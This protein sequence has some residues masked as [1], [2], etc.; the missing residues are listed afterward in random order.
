[1][2]F[3]A[4]IEGSDPFTDK[5]TG[6]KLVHYG[7]E[8]GGINLPV[9][10]SF[11][12]SMLQ[13][14]FMST[15]GQNPY[16]PNGPQGD[17]LSLGGLPTDN[18][19]DPI[20]SGPWVNPDGPEDEYTFDDWLAD[21]A[22]LPEE[23]RGLPDGPYGGTKGGSTFDPTGGVR[24]QDPF[25]TSG[26]GGFDAIGWD[27]STNEDFYAQQFADARGQGARN[28]FGEYLGRERTRQ[29]NVAERE[30]IAGIDRND[31]F[32][33]TGGK[34]PFAWAEGGSEGMEAQVAGAASER[35]LNDRLVEGMTASQMLATYGK[36]M[37]EKER[38]YL[39]KQATQEGSNWSEQTNWSTKLRN[40]MSPDE[41]LS[42]IGGQGQT[43]QPNEWQRAAY[44]KLFN[45][46]GAKQDPSG[47]S[48]AE[49]YALPVRQQA[50]ADAAAAAATGA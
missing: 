13:G 39:T 33:M 16:F 11:G 50:Q 20:D 32:A 35:G 10:T 3:F 26:A 29:N 2:G 49:G 30:R 44:G 1:M 45:L 28:Q 41:L 48:A 5:R 38:N 12:D 31:P 15:G 19:Y 24:P 23:E 9:G 6:E 8:N 42:R 27:A 17:E 40:G 47:P 4:D 36:G 37:S 21:Q 22:Q 18:G 34:D 14:G 43:D 7:P 46:A 25:D